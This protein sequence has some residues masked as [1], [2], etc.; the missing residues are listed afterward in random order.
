MSAK[1]FEVQATVS[2]AGQ[3]VFQAPP[4]LAPGSHR[5]T[6]LVSDNT[7]EG[8]AAQF[9]SLAAQWRGET[10]ILSNVT[11]RCQHIA[12]QR[13]IGMG[14]SAVPFIL[15]DLRD[16]GPDDWFWALTA[17][18][19]KNPI[20]A[21]IVGDVQKMTEAWLQWGATAGYLSDSRRNANDTSR[22]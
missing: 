12:Y 8:P 22:A 13:I 17:I 20:S 15:R 4:E 10:R 9:Q 16:N 6:V 14:E 5:V 18:T 7:A 11:R 21:D 2:P 19:G 1:Q 3:A